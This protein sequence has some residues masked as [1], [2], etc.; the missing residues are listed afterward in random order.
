MYVLEAREGEIARLALQGERL[1]GETDT[2][3]SAIGVGA[4]WRCLDMGCGLGDVTRLMAARVGPSGAVSG[5][6]VNARYLALARETAPPGV[7]YLEGDM[8][9]SGLPHGEFD[10]VHGRFILGNSAPAETQI[11]EAVR[12]ARPGGTVA[13]QEQEFSVLAAMP[14]HPAIARLKAWLTAG[15]EQS[16]TG[17]A[18]ARRLFGM[19]QAAGL[20]NVRYRPFIVGVQGGDPFAQWLPEMVESMRGVLLKAGLAT[21]AAMD[22]TLAAGRAHLA[23][24]GTTANLYVVVQAWGTRPG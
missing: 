18:I 4:G 1:A 24:P 22:E 10:L 19:L 11:A 3:L 12:L 16:G 7:T 9:A 21:A 13:F 2:L 15:L 6:D 5:I 17:R 23:A 8:C 20:E 14:P